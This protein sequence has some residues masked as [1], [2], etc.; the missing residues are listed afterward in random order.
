MSI[1]TWRNR[2]IAKRYWAKSR[3]KS[4]NED[5]K[6][7][8]SRSS[9]GADGVMTWQPVGLGSPVLYIVLKPMLLGAWSL[10]QQMFQAL[11]I[12]IPE[13]SIAF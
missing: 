13:V 11:G 12:C 7:C 6:S 9:I 5:I 3:L 2:R 8:D 4:N 10:L 1:L